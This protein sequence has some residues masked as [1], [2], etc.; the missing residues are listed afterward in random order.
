MIDRVSHG[1]DM[2]RRTDRGQGN[3]DEAGTICVTRHGP[4]RVVVNAGI[5]PAHQPR[6]QTRWSDRQA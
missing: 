6:W 1:K 5:V 2:R 3:D 4:S